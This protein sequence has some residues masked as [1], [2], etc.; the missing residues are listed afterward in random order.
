MANWND[1]D[2]IVQK[3]TADKKRYYGMDYGTSRSL[4]AYQPPKGTPI[5]LVPNN[6]VCRKGI[7]SLMA[8]RPKKSPKDMIPE[9]MV[10]DQVLTWGIMNADPQSVVQSVKMR[11]KEDALTIQG[12]SFQTQEIVR[13]E[14][15]R[16]VQLSLQEM[17]N[18]LPADEVKKNVVLTVGV[19]VRTGDNE[20]K[21][22]KKA[23]HDAMPDANVVMLLNEPEAAALYAKSICPDVKENVLVYDQ[24]GGTFD[25]CVLVPNHNIT[26]EEPCEFRCME[27]DGNHSAG[28][29]LDQAMADEI[30]ATLE[31]N[32]SDVDLKILRDKNHRDHRTLL[33]VAREAKE[34]LSDVDTDCTFVNING[35]E[36]GSDTVV[37][38]R[39][40]YED[41]IRPILKE[42]VALAAKCLRDAKLWEN[43]NL[44]ILMVGG[45]SLIPL[46]RQLI[47]ETFSWV[48]D[49]DIICRMPDQAVALGCA[50][51]SERPL[52]ERKVAYGYAVA[53]YLRSTNKKILH[54]QIPA[55]CKLPYSVTNT[56][57]TRTE[58]QSGVV[59]QVYEVPDAKADA[60]LEVNTG[61]IT[62]MTM[63]HSFD[64]PVPIH[65]RVKVHSTLDQNGI[66]TMISECVDKRYGG[67]GKLVENI[68]IE[69]A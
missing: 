1:L 7:P 66:L 30:I 57:E 4:M 67:G 44:T 48:A 29:L 65:T 10:C 43:K 12:K 22:I 15:N 16:I 13:M 60:T 61:R 21:K 20:R 17:A 19:P 18:I 14:M 11:L 27:H 58:G 39:Q 9:E 32:G 2:N 38:T 56:Y 68:G 46:A 63:E 31:E 37:I 35:K 42:T 53:A 47:K 69:Y 33:N 49:S 54:V 28:D 41:R 45:S 52:V 55:D 36:C 62:K 51:F 8:Y 59:F 40:A 64:Q 26:P 25:T 3:K 50:L 24:G 5:A 34:A 23:A 6:Q